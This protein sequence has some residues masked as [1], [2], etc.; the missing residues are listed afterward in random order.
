MVLNVAEGEDDVLI[1]AS[2]AVID[3]VCH[4]KDGDSQRIG[5]CEPGQIWEYRP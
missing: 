4:E 2:A 5:G 1:I 3:P